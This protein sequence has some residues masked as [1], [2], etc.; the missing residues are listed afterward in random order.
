MKPI[1][2]SN[3]SNNARTVQGIPLPTGMYVTGDMAWDA[4]M[5][6]VV[7][8]AKS[9]FYQICPNGEEFFPYSECENE[10]HEDDVVESQLRATLETLTTTTTTTSEQSSSDAV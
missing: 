9:L 3:E 6:D 1:F 10:E 7:E 5:D 2:E 4:H 8:Q